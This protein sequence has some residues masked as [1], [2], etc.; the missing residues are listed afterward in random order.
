MI[1]AMAVAGL[2]RT[3]RVRRASPYVIGAGALSW[4]A[5][6][7]GGLEPA[8]ALVPV[9][10][11]V[12][13]ARRD[14]GFFAETPPGAHDPLSRFERWARHPTQVVLLLFGIVAAGVPLRALDWGTV[15]LPLA[16]LIGKPIGLLIGAGLARACGL[17]LPARIGWRELIVLGLVAASGFTVALFF[18][19]A[20]VG[21]GPTLSAL[22]MGALI[23]GGAVLVAAAAAVLLRV[24]RFSD[25]LTSHTS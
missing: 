19:A 13:H 7:F 1:A 3:A 25:G 10:P 6:Y 15:G 14:R 24:G 12:P 2:L 23:S 5:L 8:F 11:F 4:C 21:P 9:L 17:S 16:T 18:A 20:A 22:K